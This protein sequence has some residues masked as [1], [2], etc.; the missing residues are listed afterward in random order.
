MTLTPDAGRG[1]DPIADEI[2]ARAL[3][4]PAPIFPADIG[5]GGREPDLDISA[6]VEPAE[7]AAIMRDREADPAGPG[8]EPDF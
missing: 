6:R 1:E 2:D 3:G 8:S 7:G 4:L 5:S